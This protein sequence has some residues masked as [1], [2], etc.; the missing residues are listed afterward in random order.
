MVD[1]APDSGSRPAAAGEQWSISPRPKQARP[2]VV[3]G[4]G[5]IVENAHLPAYGRAQFPVVA[6]ADTAPGKAQALAT[7][8]GVQRAFESVA[9]IVRFAPPDAVYDVAVPAGKMI[10]VI[11][12][13]PNGAPVLLQKP[14][15]E[16]L[17]EARRIREICH[18]KRL[19]AAV[20]FQLRYAPSILAARSLQNG[21]ILGE[22]H[23]MEIQV[24]TH[25]PWEQWSFLAKAPRIEVLY[26]SIH[27]VDL[28]RSWFGNPRSVFAKTVRN[29]GTPGLQATKSILIMDYGEWRRV[30]IA[31]NHNYRFGEEYERAFVQWEGTKGAMRATLGLILDYPKGKP[32]KLEYS[33]E[34]ERRW[35]TYPIDGQWFPDAFAGAMGSLQAYVEGSASFLPTG[36]DDAYRTMQAVEAIYHASDKGGEPIVWE[37]T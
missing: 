33:T 34:R 28:V 17:D 1:S 23:D 2:V 7:R 37:D 18:S 26:H 19:V 30:F 13:L 11:R 6:I 8:F 20:N 27:Y 3:I 24:R 16:T 10:E 25:M 4:A 21:G 9:D 12:E 31:T 29:P 35:I 15:G 14:M 5:G 22:V 32:D 36:I